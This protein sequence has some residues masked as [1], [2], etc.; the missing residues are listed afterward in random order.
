MSNLLHATEMN[1]NK[2]SVYSNITFHLCV[3]FRLLMQLAT[4]WRLKK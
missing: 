3:Y 2:M 1:M 4:P